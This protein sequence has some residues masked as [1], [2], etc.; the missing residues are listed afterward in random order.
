MAT[1]S[2][3]APKHGPADRK[4]RLVAYEKFI[5]QQIQKTSGAV[6][7]VDV[8]GG[9]MLLCAAVLGY[10]LLTAMI[11]HWLVPGG[12]NI[13]ARG[14]FFLLLVGG[15]GYYVARHVL[16]AL[17]GRVNPLYSAYTIESSS[18]ALKNSLLNFLLFRRQQEPVPQAVLEALEVQAATRLSS[19]KIDLVVDQSKV[20]KVGYALMVVAVLCALYTVFSPKSSLVS[21]S[22]V[23]LPWADILPPSRVEIE[24]IRPG[25]CTDEKAIVRGDRLVVSAEIRGLSDDEPVTLY[26][27]T[28]DGQAVDR[29]IQMHVPAGK[30]RHVCNVPGGDQ[31]VY[32]SLAYHIEAGDA[33]S[34]D[35]QVAVVAAPTIAVEQVQY[36][37]PDY[38]RYPARTVLREGD[39]EGIEGTRVTILARANYPIHEAWIDFGNDGKRDRE[40]EV[41]GSAARYSFELA[42]KKG[43]SAP[44]HDRYSLRFTNT[45][46][47]KNREPVEY[48][49]A[50]IADEPPEVAILRPEEKELQLP[51]NGMA[52]IETRAIDH[53]F[54]LQ[55]VE[56]RGEVGRRSVLAKKLLETERQGQFVG[57]YELMPQSD[58]LRVGDVLDYWVIARDNKSPDA[59]EAVTEKYRIEIVAADN[60]APQPD[61]LARNDRQP[62]RPD[63]PQEQQPGEPQ[64]DRQNQ[65][66][67]QDQGEG[68]Q[69][70]NPQDGSGDKQQPAEGQ[71]QEGQPQQ[72]EGNPQPGQGQDS[73]PQQGADPMNRDGQQQPRDGQGEQQPNPDQPQPEQGAQEGDG[74]GAPR[75]GHG[76]GWPRSARP[77]AGREPAQPG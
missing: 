9:L 44:E 37:Y 73:Q 62:N 17:F 33:R 69:Q 35:Y 50:V 16:P 76:A 8:A 25:H 64:N 18:P 43:S 74:E 55:S 67:R 68:Q 32:T 28:A 29:P 10:L 49:I 51:I 70:D 23:L 13:Y 60:S 19:V 5:E 72:G 65:E 1:A 52:V 59:N 48:R 36:E 39:L 41:A 26:Y 47:R 14:F 54:A 63:Q 30:Q 12:M 77:A 57:R 71:A 58:G 11:D 56:L 38:T 21:A 45:D 42:L 61:R 34:R 66:Q 40:M 53:D 24:D 27:S 15:A 20:L 75:D 3:Q 31:G 4:A 6:K 22:R 46:G 2:P 7:A